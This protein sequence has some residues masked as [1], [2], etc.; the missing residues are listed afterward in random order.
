MYNFKRVIKIAV[1]LILVLACFTVSVSASS[2]KVDDVP[3]DSYIFWQDDINAYSS[4]AVYLYDMQLKAEDIGFDYQS[5]TDLAYDHAGNSYILDGDAAKV[6]ILDNTYQ[7]V[8]S[9]SATADIDF[10]GAMGIEYRDGKIY[11]CD[12]ENARVLVFSK[13][14]TLMRTVRLPDSEYI[15]EDF[16]FRPIKIAVDSRGY[17]YVLSDGSYYGAILYSPTGEFLGFYGSNT[18]ETGILTAL[19]NIW[20][21]ITMTNEKRANIE[22]KLPY[23]FSDLFADDQDFIYT[24][25]GRTDDTQIGTGQIKRFNPGGINV[26]SG[27]DSTTFAD[28]KVANVRF[29]TPL[30]TIIPNICSVIVDE[31]GFIYCADRESGKIFIFDSDCNHIGV[32]GGG[33]GDVSQQGAFGKVS[34]IGFNGTDIVVLDEK[35]LNIVIMKRTPYGND[36]LSAQSLVLNGDYSESRSLWEKVLAQDKNNQ[37]AYSGLAKACLADGEYEQALKYAKDGK[38]IDT[39]DQAYEF[40]RNKFLSDNFNYIMIVLLVIAAGLIAFLIY[41]KKKGFQ[42]IRNEKLSTMFRVLTSPV[43]AF[44]SIKQKGT[45]STVLATVLMFLLYVSVVCKN[46]LGG[47]Q[48]IAGSSSEFNSL[49]TFVQTIGAVLLFT[50]SNWGVATLMQGRGTVKEV[51]ILTNYSLIPLIL[52]NFAY[53]I[54]SNFLLLSEGTFLSLFMTVMTAYT[55]LL[56]VFGLINIHDV[57]FGKFLG[58]TILSIL[59]ILVVIFIGVIVFVLAQQ[60]YAFI[61]TIFTEMIYR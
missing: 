20:E 5:L 14:G 7:C 24:A 44:L 27:S 46:E 12:T 39:Y 43:D 37:L 22:K 36:F 49:L 51:Y 6:F 2:V 41:K 61:A 10:T 25:T 57:S 32:M 40:V 28:R 11:I 42:I 30:W 50:I 17:M 58:I 33:N 60:L 47:Y 53:T 13:G 34:A 59:G 23:Q 45:G 1:A 35:K 8:S 55:V 19:Q 21:K 16:D 26:L 3:N 29:R 48:F 18:V 31:N 56:F 15:P 38:D 9:F 54:L 4:K 52:G